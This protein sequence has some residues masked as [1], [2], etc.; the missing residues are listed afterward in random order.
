MAEA[1]PPSG[2]SPVPL[3]TEMTR[4]TIRSL[5]GRVESVAFVIQA[6]AIF[7]TVNADKLS[8]NE[9]AFMILFAILHLVV[10]AVTARFGGPFYRGSFWP[11]LWFAPVFSMPILMASFV[12]PG[13]YGISPVCPQLCGYPV[14]PVA[15]AAF[16]PWIGN[17]YKPISFWIKGAIAVTIALEP[18]VVM[19]VVNGVITSNNIRGTLAQAIMVGGMWA[20]GEAIGRICRRAAASQAELLRKEYDRQFGYLHSDIETGLRLAEMGYRDQ[21]PDEVVKAL[22]ELS[23]SVLEER[24]RLSV[25]QQYVSVAEVIG[26]H[27]RRIR[28]VVSVQTVPQVDVMT[29]AQPTGALLSRALGDLLKNSIT[30]GATCVWIDFRA[31]AGLVYLEVADNAPPFPL[32]AAD[33]PTG[34]L[35]KL[36][37]ALRRA[38]GDLILEATTSDSKRKA[39]RVTISSTSHGWQVRR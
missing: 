25:A 23:H 26:L 39:A 20:A 15:I 27:I 4:T 34:S 30:H 35:F 8:R 9:Q 38:G 13:D 14:S 2:R 29:V 17:Q 19:R 32:R 10:A 28:Q 12:P 6:F 24:M 21:R 22:K 37:E 16:Y 1:F 36:R 31:D 11:L 18:L 7:S 3:N 5:V 33:D